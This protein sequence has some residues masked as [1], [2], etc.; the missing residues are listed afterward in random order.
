MSQIEATYRIETS[1]P[2][3][4]AARAMAGEQSSG[5]FVNVP[6]ETDELRERHGARVEHVTE[7]DSVDEPTLPGSSP[8]EGENDSAYTRAEVELSSLFL[9]DRCE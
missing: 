4:E 6:G 9:D 1:L 8:P 3:D 2:L 7:I 5:T